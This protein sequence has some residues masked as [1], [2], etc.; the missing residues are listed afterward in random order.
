MSK[1]KN[2]DEYLSKLE[3]TFAHQPL[4]KV[5]ELAHKAAPEIEEKIKWGSPSLE[6]K[7]L[8]ITLAA[9]KNHSAVWFHKGAIMNDPKN[10]LEASSDQTKSMR[11][12]IIPKGGE[13]DEGA[14]EELIRE[15]VIV[16]DSGKEVAG[17][18]EKEEQVERS[19]MLEQ[20]LKENPVAKENYQSLPDGK[21]REYA[22]YIELAK[23]Q[24]TKQ[25]RLKKSLELLEKGQGLNDKY[26][27]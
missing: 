9:F 14:L 13:V 10:L 22:Q 16:N 8:M 25:R 17:M 11:K 20:A 23:Q 21:K 4:S 19:E 5:R 6:Y 15:A 24:A 1:P 26:R 27:K 3:G 2:I 18:G 7:G 12:Y